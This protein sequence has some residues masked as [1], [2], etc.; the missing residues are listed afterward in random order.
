MIDGK[1]LLWFTRRG[2][3]KP[4]ITLDGKFTGKY[5]GTD[6]VVTIDSGTKIILNEDFQE[7]DFG[8]K[9]RDELTPPDNPE[10]SHTIQGDQHPE[11]LDD[12]LTDT[13]GNDLIVG[14]AGDDFIYSDAGGQD[15][16]KGV[17][18]C[19][20]LDADASTNGIMEGGADS[21]VI[22]GSYAGGSQIFGDSYG[23]M[24][25]LID[26]GETAQATG[27]KGDL[28]HGSSAGGDNFLYG[29][30]GNDLLLG[31]GRQGNA[32]WTQSGGR[33]AA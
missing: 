24:Q 4:D 8:I 7:G 5:E 33:R 1:P 29:S 19:D 23:D 11:N 2:D 27:Q 30:N 32:L 12:T 18:G 3:G 26:A 21:D 17:E 16:L 9:F 25:S 6:Y 15:W 10:T 14:G 22:F 31:L 20:L 13:A 28:I